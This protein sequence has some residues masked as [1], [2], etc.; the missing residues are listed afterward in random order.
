MINFIEFR[1]HWNY[2]LAWS[3]ICV[4]IINTGIW[5]ILLTVCFLSGRSLQFRCQN[6]E[7]ISSDLL[8]DGRPNCSDRSDETRDECRKPEIICPEYAFRC[9]YGACVD[10]D[11]TCNGVDDC[12]DRSDELLPRCRNNATT[13]T[14]SLKSCGKN[15]FKCVS[16]QC[17]PGTAICDGKADC[18]DRSDETVSLCGNIEYVH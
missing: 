14:S 11:A 6:G 15:E 9:D 3:Y 4:Q 17:V 5:E 13:N 16:G 2:L 1:I 8:C 18:T 10:G 12:V 7:C